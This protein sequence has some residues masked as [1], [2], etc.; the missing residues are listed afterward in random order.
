MLIKVQKYWHQNILK[1]P[2]VKVLI[3]QIGQFR[4]NIL[5][6]F[7]IIY[8]D[9]FIIAGNGGIHFNYLIDCRVACEFYSWCN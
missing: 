6:I 3:M 9:V 1:V 5:F 4:N 7:I 8:I 2:K